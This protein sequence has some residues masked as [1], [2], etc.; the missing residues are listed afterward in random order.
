MS[1]VACTEQE[2]FEAQQTEDRGSSSAGQ[3]RETVTGQAGKDSP[4]VGRR[5][6]SRYA[7]KN[8][9]GTLG[10]ST[11]KAPNKQKSVKTVARSGQKLV[12]STL[13]WGD[14]RQQQQQLKEVV[15]ATVDIV[16]AA[17]D[18]DDDDCISI[19]IGDW[20]VATGFSASTGI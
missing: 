7:Q 14:M 15:Q 19:M 4:A 20:S 2:K 1:E 5:N 16:D 9:V 6:P 10:T 8:E 11:E 17:E 18:D 12:D 3:G 13:Q